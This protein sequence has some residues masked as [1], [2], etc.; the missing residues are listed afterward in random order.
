MFASC[1]MSQPE[2]SLHGRLVS[3]GTVKFEAL[4]RVAKQASESPLGFLGS[5][6]SFGLFSLEPGSP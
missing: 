6:V 5:K 1:V 3:A 2:S 4:L